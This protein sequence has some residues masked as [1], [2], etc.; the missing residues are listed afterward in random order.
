MKLGNDWRTFENFS[1]EY[2]GWN[3]V[4]RS[5]EG[6]EGYLVWVWHDDDTDEDMPTP[7]YYHSKR[8]GDIEHQDIEYYCKGFAEAVASEDAVFFIGE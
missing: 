2:Q 1:I 7:K 5:A 8:N 4:V 6:S 3:Y